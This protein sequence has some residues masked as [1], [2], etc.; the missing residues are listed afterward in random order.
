[1][2]LKHEDSRA[3]RLPRKQRRQAANPEKQFQRREAWPSLLALEP[4]SR[5]PQQQALGQGLRRTGDS[6]AR[7]DTGSSAF[8]AY[9]LKHCA[10]R[11]WHTAFILPGEA[12][13]QR[14]FILQEDVLS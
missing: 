5:W 11:S 13:W 8:H 1:M 4:G 2:V 12:F 3:F 10:A 7:E 14:C 6:G 9:A